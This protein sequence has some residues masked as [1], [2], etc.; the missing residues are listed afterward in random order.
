[1][2]NLLLFSSF[3]FITII[4]YSQTFTVNNFSYEVYPNGSTTL[5]LTDYNTAGGTNVIIPSA[6]NYNGITYAI[7]EIGPNSFENKQ[8][9]SV[10]LP[11]GITNIRSAA[12]R[13]NN[14]TS[15]YLPESLSNIQDWA[16]RNNAITNIISKNTN[17]ISIPNVGANDA[18]DDRSLIDVK[19]PFGTYND[20]IS[21]WTGF[22]SLTDKLVFEFNHITYEELSVNPHTLVVK[23]YDNA[24][25]SDVTIPSTLTKHGNTYTV[26]TIGSHAFLFKNITSI[27]MPN[28]IVQIRSSAFKYNQLTSVTIPE[29]VTHIQSWAFQN[30]PITTFISENP[31]PPSIPGAGSTDIFDDRSLVNLYIPTGSTSIYDISSWMGFNTITEGTTLSTS[32]EV[33]KQEVSLIPIQ[34]AIKINLANSTKLKS[35]TI[36]NLSG[37][38]IDTNTTTEFSTSNLSNGLYLIR[39]TLNKGTLVKKFLITN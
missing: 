16:F 32:T 2:R 3:L 28:T 22:N 7:T 29:S 18:F 6:V 30:N 12:F 37:A 11:Y 9:T 24:G 39:L 5:R 14:L 13:S 19:V 20:Y 17:V 33:L 27:T 8:L 21:S 36:Y 38:E 23:S 25:G 10:I 1:M 26:T 31:S 35:Y 4:S 15:I 34:G